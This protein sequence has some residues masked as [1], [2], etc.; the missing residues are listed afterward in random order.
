MTKTRVKALYQVLERNPGYA[1]AFAEYE[2][3][4]REIGIAEGHLKALRRDMDHAETQLK[5]C[6][7]KLLTRLDEA[8]SDH[9]ATAN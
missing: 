9:E 4:D 5:E 1:R 6:Q 7:A 2:R 3:L 8:V